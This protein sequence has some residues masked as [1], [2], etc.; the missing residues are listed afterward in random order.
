MGPGSI[1]EREKP[2][3]QGEIGE[4]IAAGIPIPEMN[5]PYLIKTGPYIDS[6]QGIRVTVIVLEE[7]SS[8]PYNVAYFRE[9]LPPEAISIEEIINQPAELE[10]A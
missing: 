2:I 5:T 8:H 1:V 3:N 7:F 4:Y 6:W 9:L 10:V